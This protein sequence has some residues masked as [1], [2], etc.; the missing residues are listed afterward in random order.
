MLLENDLVAIF[1]QFPFENLF[2][3]LLRMETGQGVFL[4]KPFLTDGVPIFF[5][6]DL[7]HLSQ[8]FIVKCH[9]I[10]L[11]TLLLFKIFY[12]NSKGNQTGANICNTTKNIPKN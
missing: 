12:S 1:E 3:Y 4:L 2:H 8:H 9:I 5:T 10:H 7:L 6:K 11:N